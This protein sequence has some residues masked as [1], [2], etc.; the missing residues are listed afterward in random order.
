LDFK[1][2]RER[3][4]FIGVLDRYHVPIKKV[5]ASQYKADCPLP[6]HTN[7]DEHGTFGVNT[8][9]GVF[10]CFSDSCRKA[11]NGSQGNV[12]DF[13]AQMEGVQAYD[14]AAKLNEWFPNGLGKVADNQNAPH[15]AE[16]NGRGQQQ[17]NATSAAPEVNRPLAF[18]LKGI[19]PQHSLIQSRGISIE[20]ARKYG[21]GFF[22]G[23]GSMAG[24]V[25][26]ELREDG[27]LVGYAG[28]A[29]DGQEPRWKLPAGLHKTFLFGLEFCTPD[30][31]LILTE[32]F[33]AP[34]YYREQGVNA[35]ALMGKELTPAQE[36]R[37]AP[38]KTI[39]VAMDNDEPGRA[40]AERICAKLKP[41]HKV[42]KA[43]LME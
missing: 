31:P 2:V 42:L 25:V 36:Q 8:D 23:K 20:T 26:F 21:V 35:A 34:P 17:E 41:N 15:E 18:Q 40:A 11:G 6:S 33:W 43:H 16:R 24:R 1:A 29:T 39:I 28:R 10:K 14:A 27:N 22:P 3:A 12:L 37:L 7:K 19:E 9:K 13:V 38:F 4:S 5:S 32:S 30:Q